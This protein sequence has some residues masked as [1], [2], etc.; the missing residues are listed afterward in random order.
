MIKSS[1]TRTSEVPSTKD[2]SAAWVTRDVTFPSG[3]EFRARHKH[4]T[5]FGKVEDGALVVNGQ[6]YSSPSAAAVAITN[7]AV[8]GWRF[9]E[10]KFPDDSEWV[11]L[12]AL[13]Q[14]VTN[15]S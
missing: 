7:T 15:S 2:T 8:N 10:C 6:S 12:A 13:R 4:I 9:W 3:T 5:Y 14:S 1:T 11:S